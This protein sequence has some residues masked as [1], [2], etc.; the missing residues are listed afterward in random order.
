M[1]SAVC[2]IAAAA[3]TWARRSCNLAPRSLDHCDFFAI[4]FVCNSW[5]LSDSGG[6]R[7]TCTLGSRGSQGLRARAA[8]TGHDPDG[9]AELLGSFP[10]DRAL[11]G[12]SMLLA[13]LLLGLYGEQTG[14]S[15]E[16]C[17]QELNSTPRERRDGLITRVTLRTV[18]TRDR[19]LIRPVR[20][21]GRAI[22]WS[23][24]PGPSP[25]PR[26]RSWPPP[27]AD[28]T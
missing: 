6:K 4:E 18:Q 19:S 11:A 15:V 14:Q 23:W 1:N 12:G 16:Q 20:T 24:S 13:Q 7:G 2:A 9:V 27:R 17:V 28:P 10:N 25:R 26:H 3:L 8:V 5:G 21:A 22:A